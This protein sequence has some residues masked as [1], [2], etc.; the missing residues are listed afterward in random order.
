[1]HDARLLAVPTPEPSNKR[2]L[3]GAA[4]ASP[5]TNKRG[6]NDPEGLDITKGEGKKLR[7]AL[8]DITNGTPSDS[9]KK[10]LWGGPGSVPPAVMDID[11]DSH[12]DPQACTFCVERIYQNLRLSERRRRP[13]TCY[14]ES[15]QR[16]I[17]S[18]MRAILVDWMVE[19]ASEYRLVPET[20]HLAVSYVDRYLSVTPVLRSK[21]QLVGI[22]ATLIASKYEE[23]YAPQLDEFCYITD[24]AYS[25]EEL[26]LCEKEM[27]RVLN[28]ELTV[29]T[30]RTFTKRFLRAA[31]ADS[32][33]EFLAM[34]LGEISLTDYGMLHFLPSHVAASAV[35]LALLTLGKP[36]M[37]PTLLYHLGYTAQE[38][39]VCVRSLHRQF[40]LLRKA[41]S[42]SIRDKFAM[43]TFKCVSTIAPSHPSLPDHIFQ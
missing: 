16:D 18:S 26:L 17:S 10:T 43:H 12:D 20:L 19:V 8:H 11:A 34:Y 25:K 14:M 22:T 31:Q 13:S 35:F 37:S 21:L 38:L 39:Q 41:P 40:V 33:T 7:N 30:V 4:S 42:S 24:H 23:I 36:T 32:K 29:P 6:A 9:D 28:Y 15:V 3:L 2:V 5:G 27:L 1:M